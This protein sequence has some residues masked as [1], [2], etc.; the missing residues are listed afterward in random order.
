MM[1]NECMSQVG[2]G[3]GNRRLKEET[4]LIYVAKVKCKVLVTGW[5]QRVREKEE[6]KLNPSFQCE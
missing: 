6:S 1:G 5:M 3:G 2:A 4:S